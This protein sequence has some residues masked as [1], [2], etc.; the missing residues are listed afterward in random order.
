MTKKQMNRRKE[1]ARILFCLLLAMPLVCACTSSREH[2]LQQIESLLDTCPD[3]SWAMLCQDSIYLGAYSKS[4]RMRHLLLRAEAMNKLFYPMDSLD[5]MEEVLDYYS[6]HGSAEEKA[7]ASYMMGSVYRDR[8]NSPK[9][10]QY[11]NEAVASFGMDRKDCNLLLLSK[12][13]GQIAEIYRKQRYPQMEETALNKKAAFALAANDTLGYIQ[14]LERRAG[15]FHQLGK[16]DSVFKITSQAYRSYRKIGRE[17]YAASALPPLTDIYLRRKEYAKAKQTLDEYRTKSKLLDK[18]GDPLYP[19]IEFYYNYLGMYYKEVGLLDS[20]LWCY[21]K[22][23]NYPSDI[24]DLEAGYRGM[25]SVYSC[26]GMADSVVKYARLYADANDTANFRNSAAEVSKVQALFDYT[27]SQKVAIRKA[28]EANRAWKT[29]SA[30]LFIILV[31]VFFVRKLVRSNQ[32]VKT[33]LNQVQNKLVS[34]QNV[35]K[36]QEKEM[37]DLNVMLCV[38]Q[39]NA[40]EGKWKED[41]DFMN[42]KIVKSFQSYANMGKQPTH[43][44]WKDLLVLVEKSI[45]EFWKAMSSFTSMM[46]DVEFKVCLLTRLSFTPSQIANLLGVSKQSVTNKRKKLV[47]ILFNTNDIKKFDSFIGGLG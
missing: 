7:Q 33:F 26:K 37:R 15:V 2:R 13:Y 3:S 20:A 11:Y 28:E 4:D 8:S 32:K 46:V 47:Q 12:I 9:A 18:K 30:A 10:L 19:E 29:L 25:M 5:Y 16:M 41:R 14:A 21:R 24:D 6:S 42:S 17:D 40:N 22:L 31:L 45:P 44:E 27:E 43:G 38:Y 1:F 23:L 35:L 36:L 34:T 39:T